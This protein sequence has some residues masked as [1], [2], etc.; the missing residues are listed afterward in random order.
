M[1]TRAAAFLFAPTADTWLTILRTGLGL[2]VGLYCLSLQSSWSALLSG[3]GGGIITREF[4]EAIITSESRSIP[5]LGWL[6]AGGEWLGL[7]EQTTLTA[8]WFI[9]LL[10]ASCLVAG[11]FCRASAIVSWFLY[12]CVAKSTGVLSYGVDHLTTIGLFYLMLSPLPDRR[13]LDVQLWKTRTAEA[14]FHGFFRR[15]L[16]L[17]LCVIY[18]FG[19][20]AKALGSGWWDGSNIWRALTRP[21]FDLLAPEFIVRLAAL[22]P[23]LGIAVVIVELAYPFLIWSRRTRRVWLLLTCGMHLGIGLTMGMYLF[24]LVMIV[25][26]VAAFGPAAAERAPHAAIPPAPAAV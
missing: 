17:H 15:L 21:P 2:Q 22:L 9:L 4:A 18:L 24:A 3:S 26:N 11:L 8:V 10:T 7:S 13:A 6:I 12:L 25:L 19:G 23:L 5:R 16:Q 14:I 20:F 1:R